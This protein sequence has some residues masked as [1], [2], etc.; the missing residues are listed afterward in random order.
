MR[1]KDELEEELRGEIKGRG[2][3]LVFGSPFPNKRAAARYRAAHRHG[4]GT[5]KNHRPPQP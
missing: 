2:V 3:T 1:L 5:D 4:A